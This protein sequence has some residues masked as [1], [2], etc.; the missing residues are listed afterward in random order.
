MRFLL[1]LLLMALPASAQIQATVGYGVSQPASNRKPSYHNHPQNPLLY[2]DFENP[3]GFGYDLTGWGT[4]TTSP[5]VVDA[6]YTTNVLTGTQSLAVLMS[7]DEADFATNSFSASSHVWVFFKLRVL[8]ISSPNDSGIVSLYDSSGV[9]GLTLAMNNDGNNLRIKPNC[10][11]AGQVGVAPD[12][13]VTYNVWLEYN[14]DVGGFAYANVAY[15]L[16]GVK[17]TSGSTF[18]EATAAGPGNDMSVLRIGTDNAVS[19]DVDFVIDHV[20]VDNKPIGNY[21]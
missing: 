13:N 6:N 21:P 1:L 9:C 15:S 17:P 19:Q 12:L 8:A 7:S 3:V 16:G 10:N 4:N 18:G 2:E 5:G 14:K 11:T 20:I